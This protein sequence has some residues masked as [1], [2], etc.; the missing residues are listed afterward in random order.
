MWQPQRGSRGEAQTWVLAAAPILI[1]LAAT[2][3]AVITGRSE[4]TGPSRAAVAGDDGGAEEDALGDGLPAWDPDLPGAIGRLAVF[5]G[6]PVLLTT[7]GCAAPS[8][9]TAPFTQHKPRSKWPRWL[10]HAE[11]R[12]EA[13]PRPGCRSRHLE[14]R[15]HRVGR[16]CFRFPACMSA[17]KEP[18]PRLRGT[19]TRAFAGESRRR[20]AIA[21]RRKHSPARGGPHDCFTNTAA[22][23]PATGHAA[24]P[25]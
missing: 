2:G 9:E 3:G 8:S 25:A 13:R 14:Q 21:L 22:A 16:P 24:A 23:R 15:G 17:S 11:C 19:G 18:A 1:A 10:L 4:A 5:R 12:H 6:Q 7:S 20:R